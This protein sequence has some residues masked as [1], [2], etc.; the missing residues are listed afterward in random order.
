[1]GLVEWRLVGKDEDQ[2]ELSKQEKSA[3]TS[4]TDDDDA[5]SWRKLGGPEQ[6]MFDSKK[7]RRA[8]NEQAD[9]AN[10]MAH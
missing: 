1:M 9:S 4:G 3:K 7:S 10:G 6:M 8:R 2:N 5:R